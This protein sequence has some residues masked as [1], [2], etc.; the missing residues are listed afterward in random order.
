MYNI[1]LSEVD[2]KP[3]TCYDTGLDPR[4]FARTKMSQSLIE[5]GYTVNPD[6]SCET[7]K[8]SGVSEIDGSMRVWG[9]PVTGTRFDFI[10]ESQLKL[11]PEQQSQLS[12][13]AIVF[14]IR[15]KMLLG[16]KYSTL[17]PGATFINCEN[18]SVF[19]G[20]AN[21]SNRCL[22]V[23]KSEK[24]IKPVGRFT[25]EHAA[26]VE[27]INQESSDIQLIDRYSC[28]DLSGMEA[29][30]F[31]AGAM[32]YKILS[33]NHPYPSDLNIF[34]DMREG[35]FLPIHLAAPGLN[36]ELCA[37]INSALM[38]P[39]EKSR[40]EKN[41]AEIIIK[42]LNILNTNEN[43]IVSISSLFS[44]L[45][46]EETIQLEKTKKRFLLIQNTTT[47]TRRFA[48]R[49]KH[50]LIGIS[51]AAVFLLFVVVSTSKSYSQRLTTAGMDSETVINAYYD[52][53]SALDH[54]FMEA[55]IQGADKTDINA[56][57]SLFALVKTRQAYERSTQG[58]VPA[59]IWRDSGRELPSPNAFGVTD[60]DIE[61]LS[62]SE[63]D[64]MI[65]YRVNYTLWSPEEYSI[66]R[67]DVLTLRRDRKNNW[68]I[69]EILRT[70]R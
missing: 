28:P 29:A 41:G 30:A 25:S 35:I 40:T 47:G 12:L 19:F 55:C 49:N 33:G 16:D 9:P 65:M 7:W 43:Q 31:C 45:P 17:S 23:E 44:Q 38:L 42:L 39:V 60:L 6:G 1:H 67:T 63:T 14:W 36:E 4:S 58:L 11:P 10:L 37:F 56:A 70:E 61:H 18:G 20:P 50:A 21:L 48:A 68:R 62:G 27:R 69:A 2:G 5:N 3:A 53:F 51:L 15:A 24:K 54:M 13:Q 52:A 64:S 32:L 57:V 8:A 66:N 46:K 59:R 34:Q 22:I 26:E